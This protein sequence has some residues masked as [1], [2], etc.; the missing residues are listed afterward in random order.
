MSPFPPFVCVVE[1]VRGLEGEGMC[2][3]RHNELRGNLYFVFE[4]EFPENS[5]MNE[6]DLQVRS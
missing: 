2:N 6:Q 1:T 5:F 3:P 4:V